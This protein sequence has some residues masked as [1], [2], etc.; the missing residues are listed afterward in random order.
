MDLT[1]VSL[2]EVDEEFFKLTSFIKS[3]KLFRTPQVIIWLFIKAV[4]LLF[5]VYVD[6]SK[7][8]ISKDKQIINSEKQMNFS[9]FKFLLTWNILEKKLESHSSS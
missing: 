4:K 6:L 1:L 7:R 2:I 3:Q 9:F 5:K 8:K